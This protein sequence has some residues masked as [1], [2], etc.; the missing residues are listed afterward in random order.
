MR[1][2]VFAAAAAA[3]L[4]TTDGPPITGVGMHF[5]PGSDVSQAYPVR[6]FQAAQGGIARIRCMVAPDGKAKDC[7]AVGEAP[8]G[9]GFGRA[10]V[11]MSKFILFDTTHDGQSIAGKT[12]VKEIKFTHPRA[13]ETMSPHDQ[14]AAP[15]ARYPTEDEIAAVRPETTEPFGM[16]DVACKT[17]A[18]DG[19]LSDCAVVSESPAG[20]GFGA[21]ALKLA[22]KVRPRDPTEP[23]LTIRFLIQWHVKKEYLP[24][25]VPMEPTV[26]AAHFGHLEVFGAY[27]A[28]KTRPTDREIAMVDPPGLSAP[29]T[30]EMTCEVAWNGAK[31]CTAKAKTTTTCDPI[32]IGKNTCTTDVKDEAD[33]RYEAAAM[34]LAPRYSFLPGV[35]A[36]FDKDPRVTYHINWP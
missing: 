28:F 17:V 14:V 8:F 15:W 3:G 16:A 35:F 23:K 22:D 18:A 7:V 9:E 30:V 1:H 10:A 36:R 21:A 24:P 29:A 2:L 13:T 11:A 34:T 12:V 25:G 19:A 33:P 5:A 32:K 4:S 27:W 31:T 6:A 20:A 26:W